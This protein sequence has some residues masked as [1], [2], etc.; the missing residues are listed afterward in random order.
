VKQ[1][2]QEGD[3]ICP[4]KRISTPS[5]EGIEFDYTKVTRLIIDAFALGEAGKERSVN[6]SAS[7][8]AARVTNNLSQTAAGLKITDAGGV[9]PLKNMQSFIVDQNSLRG[10]QSQN[11]FFDEDNFD[12]R[13]KRVIFTV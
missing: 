13:N 1:L 2:E 10:S 9:D 4:F 8:D 3:R 6:V 12:K 5:G 7:I 11:T